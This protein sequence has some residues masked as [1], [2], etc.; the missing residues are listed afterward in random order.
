MDVLPSRVHGGSRGSED[1]AD[2]AANAPVAVAAAANTVVLRKLPSSDRHFWDTAQ[3]KHLLQNVFDQAPESRKRK[4]PEN[5]IVAMALNEVAASLEDGG[6]GFFYHLRNR[7]AW[8]KAPGE[9]TCPKG[10]VPVK[11]G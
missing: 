5:E 8:K 4:L 2:E 7:D 1:I 3:P 10:R 6:R 11:P 9:E